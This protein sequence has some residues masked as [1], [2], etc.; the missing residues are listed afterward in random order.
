ML[1]LIHCFRHPHITIEYRLNFFKIPFILQ[2][3]EH[4]HH[5]FDGLSARKLEEQLDLFIII[6]IEEENNT[7]NEG[8]SH[9]D[10]FLQVPTAPEPPLQD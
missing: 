8:S 9:Q 10:T 1:P 3:L 6:G 4:G 7:D 2:K 5:T